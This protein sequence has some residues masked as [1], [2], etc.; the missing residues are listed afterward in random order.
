MGIHRLPNR[1]MKGISV[2]QSSWL[3]GKQVSRLLVKD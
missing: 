1:T 2:T 3:W